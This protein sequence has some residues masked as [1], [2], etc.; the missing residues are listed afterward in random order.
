MFRARGE[1][2]V[3]ASKVDSLNIFLSLLTFYFL[4]SPTVCDDNSGSKSSWI[5]N[6]SR[7]FFVCIYANVLREFCA[8]YFL[9]FSS[10][11]GKNL[12]VWKCTSSMWIWKCESDMVIPGY[13]E[14]GS[15]LNI[16][17]AYYWLAYSGEIYI[18]RQSC[19][20][21][22]TGWHSWEYLHFLTFSPHLQCCNKNLLREFFFHVLD[23][24]IWFGNF[25]FLSDILFYIP[26]HVV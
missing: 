13:I 1:N 6:S 17:I 16:F 21:I 12:C 26:E 20:T 9:L 3:E 11:W 23:T 4:K 18:F 15:F 24:R 22:T 7:L 14:S 10:L 2:T 8:E 25:S 19:Y 5:V